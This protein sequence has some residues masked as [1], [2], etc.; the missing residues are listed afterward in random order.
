MG[1]AIS[2]EE[3]ER[4]SS[5]AI[6]EGLAEKLSGKDNGKSYGT[7]SNQHHG[8]NDCARLDYNQQ[9]EATRASH[10]RCPSEGSSIEP[11]HNH[12]LQLSATPP[13]GLEMPPNISCMRLD[14]SQAL[15]TSPHPPSSVAR[16]HPFN[17]SFIQ[18]PPADALFISVPHTERLKTATGQPECSLAVPAARRFIST[19]YSYFDGTLRGSRIVDLACYYTLEAQKS[20]SVGG[21][22]SVVTGRPDITT[23]LCNF[24]G[25]SFEVR[26]VVAQDT[27]DRKGVHILVTGIAR[28]N[29]SGLQGGVVASFAHSVSLVPIDVGAFSDSSDIACTALLEALAIGYPFQIHNDALALLSGESGR[30]SPISSPRSTHQPSLPPGLF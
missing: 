30:A 20:V 1:N 18:G 27:A 10:K 5:D 4:H 23:Q 16:S 7:V 12:Q 11:Q 28:T 24:A 15:P 22:H 17:A 14:D 25:T 19:Y 21:A 26:G 8:I 2:E 3:D 13:P 9:L 29:L 6:S